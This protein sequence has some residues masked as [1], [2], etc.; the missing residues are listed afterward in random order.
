VAAEAPAGKSYELWIIAPKQA[1]KSLGVI[2]A[3]AA[4]GERRLSA[5]DPAA[6]RDATYAVTIEQQGG[7]PTGRPTSAPVFFG[8]L[9]PV[10]P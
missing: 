2:D 3:N 4:S 7:S 10:G 6:V 5:G 8:K 1:P 9:V